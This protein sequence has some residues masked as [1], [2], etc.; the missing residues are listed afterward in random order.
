[1]FYRIRHSNLKT[2]SIPKEWDS[3]GFGMHILIET[4]FHGVGFLFGL[5]MYLT[6]YELTVQCNSFLGESAFRISVYDAFLL[7]AS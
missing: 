6:L 2:L 3:W 7:S 5:E 4:M 1:M